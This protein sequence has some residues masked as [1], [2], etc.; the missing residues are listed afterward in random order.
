M[1]TSVFPKHKKAWVRHYCYCSSTIRCTPTVQHTT[2]SFFFLCIVVNVLHQL[3]NVFEER[4]Q[5]RELHVADKAL[6]SSRTWAHLPKTRSS[7][8]QCEHKTPPPPPPPGG[9]AAARN[10]LSPIHRATAF[11]MRLS[12]GDNAGFRPHSRSRREEKRVSL[13]C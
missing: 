10:S 9:A 4:E 8:C 1:G 6:F 12:M 2:H 3:R 7:C 5:K 13:P 11:Y